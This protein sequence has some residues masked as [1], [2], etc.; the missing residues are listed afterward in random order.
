V[1][2]KPTS[3]LLLPLLAAALC[4]VSPA[5]SKR[6]TAKGRYVHVFLDFEAPRFAAAAAALGDA[7]YVELAELYA[8]PRGK[9][10]VSKPL[11][12]RVFLNRAGME[13]AAPKAARSPYSGAPFEVELAGKTAYVSLEPEFS[14][15]VWQ[16]MGIVGRGRE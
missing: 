15:A 10:R 9:R 4:P 11:E 16:D 13:A 5:Q 7:V 2:P 14:P 8:I 6:P 12:L 3:A 1:P